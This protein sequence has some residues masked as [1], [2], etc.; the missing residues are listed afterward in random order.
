MLSENASISSF[1]CGRGSSAWASPWTLIALRKP[2]QNLAFD[3]LPQEFGAFLCHRKS[4]QTMSTKNPRG[5]NQSMWGGFHGLG[6]VSAGDDHRFRARNVRTTGCT[7]TVLGTPQTCLAMGCGCLGHQ[8]QESQQGW[9]RASPL[10]PA[11]DSCGLLR[12]Q[13]S[14][15]TS[16]LEIPVKHSSSAGQKQASSWPFLMQHFGESCSLEK[17]ALWERLGFGKWCFLVKLFWRKPAFWERLPFAK[18]C[19]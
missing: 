3:A 19:V 2:A 7:S 5:W 6:M 16:L 17:A 1:D 14:A 13:L 18:D 4:S 8:A 10:P 12:A 15:A 9:S 11:T